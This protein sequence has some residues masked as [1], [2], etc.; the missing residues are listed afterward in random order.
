M[1][2]FRVSS[3]DRDV[4]KGQCACFQVQICSNSQALTNARVLLQYWARSSLPYRIRERHPHYWN[5]RRHIIRWNLAVES[6]EGAPKVPTSKPGNGVA[7]A[8]PVA[9]GSATPDS[10]AGYGSDYALCLLLT[11]AQFVFASPPAHD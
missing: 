10:A 1:D 5:M 7:N 11:I 9:D 3:G 6:L 8:E 2:V 4:V